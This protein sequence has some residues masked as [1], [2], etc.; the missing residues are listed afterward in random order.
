MSTKPILGTAA[1]ALAADVPST[2]TVTQYQ[3]LAERLLAGLAELAA[4]APS[5][6]PDDAANVEFTRRHLNVPVPFLA[7]A[8]F[9]VERNPELQAAQKLNVPFG[10][11]TLQFLDAYRPVLD[12]ARVFLD[13]L[14]LAYQTRQAALTIQA[15]HVYDIAKSVD[16]DA[17]SPELSAAVENMKRDLGRKGARRVV[18]VEVRQAAKEAA[19]RASAAVIAAAAAVT[20]PSAQTAE[21]RATAARP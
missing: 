13:R 9:A 6:D 17:R 5:L 12:A 2:F 11:D 14:T 4:I 7:T 15:L 10:R 19:A 21:P 3:Q 1:G 16:R 18:P 20:P 8:V